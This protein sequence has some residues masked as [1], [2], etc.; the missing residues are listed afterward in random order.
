[1]NISEY[2]GN[3]EVRNNTHPALFPQEGDGVV[4]ATVLKNITGVLMNKK[5]E[6]IFHHRSVLDESLFS[7]CLKLRTGTIRSHKYCQ[8]LHTSTI[9]TPKSCQ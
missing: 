5:D 1:M 4:D 2:Y 6:H 9:G 3:D 7:N 8:R